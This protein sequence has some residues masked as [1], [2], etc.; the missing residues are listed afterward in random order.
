MRSIPSIPKYPTAKVWASTAAIAQ[1]G[2]AVFMEVYRKK[3]N[4]I[5]SLKDKFSA[6]IFFWSK[7]VLLRSSSRLSLSNTNTNIISHTFDTS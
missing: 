5:Y 1:H 7:L 2:F 3:K 6:F 4:E